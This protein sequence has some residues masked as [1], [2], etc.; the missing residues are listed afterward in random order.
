VCV[1]AD[2]NSG[3]SSA[4]KATKGSG[5]SFSNPFGF[6]FGGGRSGGDGGAGDRGPGSVVQ[7][8]VTPSSA[9]S[10][11]AAAHLHPPR[12]PNVSSLD[13][14]VAT[15]SAPAPAAF[16][17]SAAAAAAVATPLAVLSGTPRSHLRGSRGQSS[18]AAQGGAAAPAAEDGPLSAEE[19]HL[20]KFTRV[21]GDDAS[22]SRGGLVS[23]SSL[24]GGEIDMAALRQASWR[25]VPASVRGVAWKLLLGYLPARRASQAATLERRRRECVGS[26]LV[27]GLVLVVAGCGGRGQ[28][29]L[30]IAKLRRR[31]CT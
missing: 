30:I 11:R 25:G 18:F 23:S 2:N 1:M 12:R 24:A 9:S 21:L 15:P 27:G 4:N 3:E 22:A 8:A 28:C 6:L 29:V 31:N 20:R 5:F 16:S 26:M 17:T 7:R 13:G 19:F 10:V 14:G